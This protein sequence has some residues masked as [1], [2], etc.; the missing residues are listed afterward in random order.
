MRKGI[1]IA[2]LLASLWVMGYETI[3][4]AEVLEGEIKTVNV[5]SSNIAM[6]AKD[7]ATGQM[8][9]EELLVK[10]SS[11][12]KL[13]NVASLSELRPGD[14]IKVETDW[15]KK[16]SCWDAKSLLVAKVQIR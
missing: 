12:T 16:T 10:A 2:M 11:K 14:E 5:E 15:N 8:A 1:S 13:E 4:Y 7:P 9:S 6:V 3:V